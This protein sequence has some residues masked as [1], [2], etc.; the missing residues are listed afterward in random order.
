[1]SPVTAT[2]GPDP[3]GESQLSAAE[4]P[5]AGARARSRAAAGAQARYTAGAVAAIDCGTNST[6]LLIVGA[7]HEVLDREMRITR[8]G[9]GVDATRRLSPRAIARTIEVLQEYRSIMDGRGVVAARLVA[10]SATRDATNSEEFFSEAERAT[11]V[12]P[13]LLSGDEEGRL[14]FAGA[15]MR[16]PSDLRRRLEAEGSVLVV[17]I[18]GGSTELVV[19]ALAP[20]EA[21]PGAVDPPEPGP[22]TVPPPAGEPSSRPDRPGPV[23][24]S[25]DI[26]CVRVSERFFHHDPPSVEELGTAREFAKSVLSDAKRKLP[27]LAPRGILIGLA[28]TVSTIAALEVGVVRYEREAIH[29]RELGRPQV[30]RWLEILAHDDKATRLSRKGMAAGREDVIVGGVLVLDAV[31]DVFDRS[32]CVVSEDDI[33]D[34][35]A[36]S[37]RAVGA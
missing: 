17:D 16:L 34:G 2:G 20:P 4:T 21:E 3:G 25:V 30:A 6:R 19:G 7:D 37:I 13:E 9:E 23:G 22:G 12:R 10:T 33:L 31:M 28:G 27:E 36:Q 14:S 11:G 32:V 24:V 26:G 18:G 5:A 8:L 35:L 1:M 29:H 15:T